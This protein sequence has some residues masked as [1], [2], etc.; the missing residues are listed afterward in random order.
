MKTYRNIGHHERV[1]RVGIGFFCFLPYQ[2]FLYYRNA[3]SS[4]PG[5]EAASYAST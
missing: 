2:D 5:D 3:R 1:V 4:H